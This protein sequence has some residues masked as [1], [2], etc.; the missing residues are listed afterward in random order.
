MNT[1]VFALFQKY[2]DVLNTEVRGRAQYR[3]IAMQCAR[4]ANRLG[5]RGCE[6]YSRVRLEYKKDE[7]GEVKEIF[8]HFELYLILP[9]PNNQTPIAVAQAVT[10]QFAPDRPQEISFETMLES[11][12]KEEKEITEAAS[13]VW[14]RDWNFS[15]AEEHAILTSLERNWKA[16]ERESF[17]SE[18]EM[19]MNQEW[20]F[21]M[22][23]GARSLAPAGM[24]DINIFSA[25]IDKELE[26]LSAA[27]QEAKLAECG[28]KISEHLQALENWE[29]RSLL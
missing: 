7:I 19:V 4:I 18:T 26:H 12:D 3:W 29:M 10:H 14:Q 20:A 17:L 6:I 28:C 25:L 9:P 1:E 23:Q 11:S 22:I 13:S 5:R 15:E 27:D 2:R 16:I 8:H 21:C 24:G